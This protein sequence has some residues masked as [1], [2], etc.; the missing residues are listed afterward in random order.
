[1]GLGV[2]IVLANIQENPAQKSYYNKNILIENNKFRIYNPT[3]LSMK[4]VDGLVFRN[5]TVERN[6]E[7][8]L[9]PWFATQKL[10]PFVFSNSINLKLQPLRDK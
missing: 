1:V 7:Y 2:I 8:K 5:N 6:D 3:I 4:S 9:M 10:E